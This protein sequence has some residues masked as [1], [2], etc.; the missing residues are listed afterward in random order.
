MTQ[1]LP[2]QDLRPLRVG[3]GTDCQKLSLAIAGSV[4]RKRPCVVEFIGAGAGN[5]AIKAVILANGLLGKRGLYLSIVP[6]FVKRTIKEDE[7][8][9]IQYQVIVHRVNLSADDV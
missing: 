7:V 9:A 4:E 1:H 3:A 8:S 2:D 6:Q 5:Q